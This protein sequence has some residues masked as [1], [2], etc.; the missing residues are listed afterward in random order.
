MMICEGIFL[1]VYFKKVW[2]KLMQQQQ[3]LRE[4]KK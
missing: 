1:D 2:K 4:K 3:F